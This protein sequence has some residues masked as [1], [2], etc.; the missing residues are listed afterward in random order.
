MVKE[1]RRAGVGAEGQKTKSAIRCYV[2]NL[3]LPLMSWSLWP[4]PCPVQEVSLC[5]VIRF[6]SFDATALL[7]W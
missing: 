1:D 6:Q 2:E 3:F 4:D 7:G 5:I